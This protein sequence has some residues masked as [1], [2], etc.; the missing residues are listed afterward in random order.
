MP[1]TVR[2]C[3][4]S[5]NSATAEAILCSTLVGTAR[6][7]RGSRPAR[8]H[9]APAGGRRRGGQPGRLVPVPAAGTGAGAGADSGGRLVALPRR[10]GGSGARSRRRRSRP[11]TNRRRS[12]ARSTRRTSGTVP[13]RTQPSLSAREVHSSHTERRLP[14]LDVDL[15]ALA[16]Q[17]RAAATSQVDARWTVDVRDV[18]EIDVYHAACCERPRTVAPRRYRHANA[19]CH[20]L[21]RPRVRPAPRRRPWPARWPGTS[22]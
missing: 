5:L 7:W 10:L 4:E 16:A 19:C 1:A 15:G 17:Q 13:S 18:P 11:G 22:S 21:A 20:G 14:P 8:L 2:R 9:A 3:S 6:T 12:C